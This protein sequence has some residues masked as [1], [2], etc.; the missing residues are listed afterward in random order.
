MEQGVGLKRKWWEKGEGRVVEAKIRRVRGRLVAEISTKEVNKKLAPS[1]NK[2]FRQAA[3]NSAWTGN[4][5][6]TGT[7]MPK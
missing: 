4:I 7:A 6:G 5:Q 1:A 2:D 3:L